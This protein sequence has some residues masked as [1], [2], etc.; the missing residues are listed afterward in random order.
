MI[1]GSP[2]MYDYIFVLLK[3]SLEYFDINIVFVWNK[4]RHLTS[5]CDKNK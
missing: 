3:L 2:F 4:F 5:N 1:I